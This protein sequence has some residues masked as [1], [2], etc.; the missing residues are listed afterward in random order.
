[1]TQPTGAGPPDRDD[2]FLDLADAAAHDHAVRARAEA[3]WRRERASDVA[4]WMG[5]LRD[6]ADR[7]AEVVVGSA[8]GRR[9]SGRLTCVG[10][11]H[12]ELSVLAGE[13]ILIAL[14]A[15]CSV[16]AEPGSASPATGDRDATDGPTL[17]EA[18]ERRM[19]ASDPCSIV[20]APGERLQGEIVALGEDVVTVRLA[21]AARTSVYLPV[22]AVLEVVGP[23]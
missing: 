17:L 8:T 20:V 9:H 6:L 7:G 23:A 12:L 13:T 10:A 4:T 15:V 21:D 5:T 1:M 18:L 19:E 16:R 11:D 2:P 14:D 22:G 3:R